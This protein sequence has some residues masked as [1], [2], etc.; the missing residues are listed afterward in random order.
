MFLAEVVELGV[1][2]FIEPT[3]ELAG[4][5]DLLLRCASRIVYVPGRWVCTESSEVAPSSELFER[6]MDVR[7]ISE[8]VQTGVE[9]AGERRRNWGR[10]GGA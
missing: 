3:M 5:G 2:L 1:L 8:L 10:C 9:P 4:I 7:A 6:L